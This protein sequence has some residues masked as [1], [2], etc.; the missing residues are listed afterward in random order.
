LTYRYKES[1]K[2][3]TSRNFYCRRKPE[4]FIKSLYGQ[5]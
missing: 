1:I 3:A 5:G 2:K 4:I